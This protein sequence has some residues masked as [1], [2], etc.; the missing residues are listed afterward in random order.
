M[1]IDLRKVPNSNISRDDYLLFSESASR[2]VV[3]ISPEKKEEFEQ[4]NDGN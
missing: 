4:N 1:E 3:T 2:I